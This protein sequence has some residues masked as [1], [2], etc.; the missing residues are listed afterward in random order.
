[1]FFLLTSILDFLILTE[2]IRAPQGPLRRGAQG[3]SLLA[4][5]GIRHWPWPFWSFEGGKKKSKEK[6]KREEGKEEKQGRESL[7]ETVI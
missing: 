7:R 4:F 6:E 5:R 3:C 1:M 2:S